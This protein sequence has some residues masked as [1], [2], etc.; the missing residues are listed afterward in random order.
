MEGAGTERVFS[1]LAKWTWGFHEHYSEFD[2]CTLEFKEHKFWAEPR[3]CLR[4]QKKR[5]PPRQDCTTSY[6]GGTMYLINQMITVRCPDSFPRWLLREVMCSQWKG[7]ATRCSGAEEIIRSVLQRKIMAHVKNLH[8]ESS[9]W[10]KQ[11]ALETK[12]QHPPDSPITYLSSIPL[13]NTWRARACCNSKSR[14]TRFLSAKKLM[15]SFV[16]IT[17]PFFLERRKDTI[18]NET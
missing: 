4:R 3:S 17:V 12:N 10:K 13:F 15:T 18:L 5:R 1:H 16:P 7:W 11:L 6:L 8:S 2:V 9:P 14:G